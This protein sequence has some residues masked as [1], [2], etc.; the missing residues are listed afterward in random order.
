MDV[1]PN[2]G[3]GTLLPLESFDVDI[4][5]NAKKAKVRTVAIPSSQIVG[6]LINANPTLNVGWLFLFSLQSSRI[7]GRTSAEKNPGLGLSQNARPRVWESGVSQNQNG[8]QPLNKFQ[9]L[10][11]AH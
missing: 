2:D 1:Q 11:L 5:F 8:S 9:I 3:F 7:W 10:A 6:K 4:M